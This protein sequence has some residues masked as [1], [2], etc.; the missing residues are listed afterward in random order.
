MLL[1]VALVVVAALTA[2][3]CG[4]S[5]VPVNGRQACAPVGSSRR[6]PDGFACSAVDNHCWRVGTGP[7]PL[8]DDGAAG[9]GGSLDGAL[10]TDAGQT[11]SSTVVLPRDAAPFEVTP[12]RPQPSGNRQVVG[13][14]TSASE[15]YRAVRSAPPPP[16]SRAM[17]S[18][19]YRMVGGLVGGTQR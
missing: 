9:T 1:R 6:C 15:N 14:Q 4:G 7:A 13:G 18:E 10:P 3:A 17:Q 12:T 19:R 8:G 11:D 5:A 16:G 2:V